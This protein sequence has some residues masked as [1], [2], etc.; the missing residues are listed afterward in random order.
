MQ[1]KFYFLLI[2]FL[3]SINCFSQISKENLIGDWVGT[4]G[5]KKTGT[6]RFLD[7]VNVIITFPDNRI[8]KGTYMLDLKDNPMRL[9][10]NST[11]GDKKIQLT[12][13]LFWVNS[14]IMKWQ[15]FPDNKNIKWKIPETKSNTL[16]MKK[17]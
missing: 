4:D 11:D 8:F 3:L 16:V 13:L 5:K 2:S 1:L 15:V 6:L 10:V 14:N 12:T 9:I 7:S 17:Q